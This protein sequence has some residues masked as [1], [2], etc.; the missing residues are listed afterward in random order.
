MDLAG[1]E[2]WEKTWQDRKVIGAINLKNYTQSRFDLIF[3]KY[4]PRSKNISLIEAGCAQSSWLPYFNLSFRYKISGIDYSETGCEK[5]QQNLLKY[6]V[7]GK[8]LC[9]NFFDENQDLF[10]QFDIVFSRGV[11]EHFEK[12]EIVLKRFYNF[13]KPEGMIVTIIPNM[14]RLMGKLQKMV[15]KPVYDLHI[16]MNLNEL[17]N[18]HSQTG[19]KEI[20][21]S[22]IGSIGT[23]VVNYPADGGLKIRLLRKLLKWLSK[24]AWST[25]KLFNYHPESETLSP[26]IIF[27]GRKIA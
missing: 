15:N 27:I 6:H 22:Y 12:P 21:S 18:F 3:S 11:I 7:E 23:E 14:T 5:A 4:L 25:F 17:R 20:Y 26:Y 10:Q 2:Y 9:R 1:Q 19:F 13:L 24:A 16:P 8:I